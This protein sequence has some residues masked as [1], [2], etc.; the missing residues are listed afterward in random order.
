MRTVWARYLYDDGNIGTPF[1][2]S[3]TYSP[4][5]ILPINPVDSVTINGGAATTNNLDVTLTLTAGIRP[6]ASSVVSMSFWLQSPPEHAPAICDWSAWEPWAST[7][8]FQLF[9]SGAGT[10]TVNV[11]YQLRDGTVTDSFSD[12]ITYEGDFSVSA[13]PASRTITAGQSTTYNVVAIPGGYAGLVTWSLYPV[14]GVTATFNPTTVDPNIQNLATLTVATTTQMPAG[15]Y[16]LF[17]TGT[18]TVGGLTESTTVTLTVNL[19]SPTPNIPRL[20]HI[21]LAHQ[22]NRNSRTARI[23]YYYGFFCGGV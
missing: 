19:G 13:S 18:G 6:F 21:S 16:M 17:I 9:P 23:L 8:D 12:S 2:D 10:K 1:S 20:H 14:S 4:L 22:R 7:R 15:N 11:K 5:I 3:I